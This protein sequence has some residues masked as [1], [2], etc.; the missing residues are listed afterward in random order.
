MTQAN[1]GRDRLTESIRLS[2]RQRKNRNRAKLY[3]DLKQTQLKLQA[4]ERRIER[5]KKRLQRIK[6]DG[7][8]SP[9]TKLRELTGN[10]KLPT[11]VEKHLI[12]INELVMHLLK[13]KENIKPKTK[14]IRS[15]SAWLL[16]RDL[17]S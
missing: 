5:Y 16:Q 6:Q 4:A 2:G 10:I 11:P 8:P 9:N 3:R 17:R 15:F 13:T 12:F 1:Q 14:D 7:T